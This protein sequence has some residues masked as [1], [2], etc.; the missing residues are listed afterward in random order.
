MPSNAEAPAEVRP[1]PSE[2]LATGA[3]R[4]DLSS[5]AGRLRLP[6]EMMDE[7]TDDGAET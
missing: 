3:D 6:D 2:L 4:R 1:L 5:T 7:M